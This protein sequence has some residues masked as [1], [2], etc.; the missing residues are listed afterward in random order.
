MK[1]KEKN[2]VD[3]H[4]SFYDHFVLGNDGAIN[5]RRDISLNN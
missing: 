3:A 5:G 2:N 4:V 1:R